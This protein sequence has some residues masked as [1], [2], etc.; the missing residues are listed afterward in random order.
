MFSDIHHYFIF[1][2]TNEYKFIQ[3]NS[4]PEVTV[5]CKNS[6]SLLAGSCQCW[7][8][9]HL[10]GYLVM[11]SSHSGSRNNW[12]MSQNVQMQWST[13]ME[14]GWYLWSIACIHQTWSCNQG[15]CM[16]LWNH[17]VQLTLMGYVGSWDG[18]QY[19]IAGSRFM[20]WNS[21]FYKT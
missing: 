3:M 17:R 11:L 2:S 20:G 19:W 14:S 10:H 16:C 5:E 7:Y 12:P 21:Y 1:T 13:E 6:S 8:R 18:D 4:V 15:T 9:N